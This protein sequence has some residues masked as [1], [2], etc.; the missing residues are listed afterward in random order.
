MVQ[1]A[2]EYFLKS[3][4]QPSLMP[5]SN[6]FFVK[7]SLFLFGCLG[8]KLNCFHKIYFLLSLKIEK[9]VDF[10]ILFKHSFVEKNQ[11][12]YTNRN[13][14]IGYVKNS[15]EK[16][17]EIAAPDR[18]PVW[19]IAFPYRKIKHIDN[20]SVKPRAIRFITKERCYLLMTVV[21]NNTIKNRIDNITQSSCQNQCNGNDENIGT[22]LFY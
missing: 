2:E 22:F 16:P 9:T 12:T 4:K 19:Q 6:K 10:S 20:F 13:R 8:N 15:V 11:Q 5:D 17:E 3:Q 7:R 1:C 21:K 14:C 18:E